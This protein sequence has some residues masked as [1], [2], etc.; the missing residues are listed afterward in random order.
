MKQKAVV[1]V[2]VLVLAGCA[3]KPVYDPEEQTQ[4]YLMQMVDDK[5]SIAVNAQRELVALGYAEKELILKRQQM[6]DT[7]ELEVDFIGSPKKLLEALATR[8]EY[9]FIE[10]GKPVEFKPVSIRTGRRSVIEIMRDVGYQIDPVADIVLDKQ[11]RAIR[12][13]YKK[14]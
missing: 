10:T 5:T 11:D 12:L 4:G 7:D 3:S 2:V 13:I 9:R 1:A 6:L 8:Y 14:D